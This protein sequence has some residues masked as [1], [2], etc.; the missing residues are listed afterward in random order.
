[1]ADLCA[2]YLDPHNHFI[3]CH[4]QCESFWTEW[5]AASCSV[6]CGSGG[7]QIKTRSCDRQPR[8]QSCT[9]EDTE[10]GPRDPVLADVRFY[11]TP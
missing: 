3:V 5:A 7:T 1:M 4:S 10:T 11:T 8:A 9:G 2:Q 6:S